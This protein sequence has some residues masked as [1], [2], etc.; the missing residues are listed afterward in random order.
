MIF[1]SQNSAWK[2]SLSTTSAELVTMA[3]DTNKESTKQQLKRE[4]STT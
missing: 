2:E 3:A 4:F 1:K